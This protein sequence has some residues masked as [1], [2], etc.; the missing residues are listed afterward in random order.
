VVDMVCIWGMLLAGILFSYR[1][2]CCSQCQHV[3]AGGGGSGVK[4][5]FR[6]RTV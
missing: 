6:G 2:T 3:G 5:V 4:A 1:G